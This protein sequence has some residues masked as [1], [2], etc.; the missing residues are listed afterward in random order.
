MKFRQIFKVLRV[1]IQSNGIRW[2]FVFAIAELSRRLARR[3]TS[4]LADYEQGHLLPGFFSSEIGRVLW[5]EYDWSQR[6]EEW[7]A[8]ET[9]K[10]SLVAAVLRPNIPA[11]SAVL[12][13]GPGAGRW[14]LELQPLAG[15]LVLVDVSPKCIALCRERFREASNVETIVGDGRTLSFA[16]DASFDRIW[17]FDV[18]VHISAA[19]TASYLREIRRVLREGGRAIIHHPADGG[20]AGH[21][22]TNMT[23][24]QFAGASGEAGLRVAQQFASWEH[25]GVA[26]GVHG[27]GDVITVLERASA[28]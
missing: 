20:F 18:F 14:S 2:L 16:G 21:W 3:T 26:F 22:R 28:T 25:A 27:S 12:E 19:D 11:G 7:T 10:R 23:A 17:S 5:N 9:W 24:D 13:I 8:S 1:L 15:R 4:W 6:G